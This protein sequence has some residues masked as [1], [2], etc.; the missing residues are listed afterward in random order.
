MTTSAEE[1]PHIVV[2]W[3]RRLRKK[4]HTFILCIVP[5]T[6]ELCVWLWIVKQRQSLCYCRQLYGHLQEAVVS[7]L[8]TLNDSSIPTTGALTWG[9]SP[10]CEYESSY[11]SAQLDVYWSDEVECFAWGHNSRSLSSNIWSVSQNNE[12]PAPSPDC[13]H[14]LKEATLTTLSSLLHLALWISSSLSLEETHS[15]TDSMHQWDFN[16]V[17]RMNWSVQCVQMETPGR[18]PLFDF[19]SQ[20]LDSEICCL[21][22]Q[23]TG[24]KT[25]AC[26]CWRRG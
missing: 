24:Y 11:Q 3:L 16:T 26:C 25:A 23:V 18:W 6:E 2:T 17:H 7:F 22:H 4:H 1:V 19:R 8:L 13:C 5:L 14:I 9:C 12:S 20:W 15:G 21:Q 10:Q